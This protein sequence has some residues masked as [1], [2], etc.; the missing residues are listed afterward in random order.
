MLCDSLATV[1]PKLD[2]VAAV[3]LTQTGSE[4][5]TLPG[6]AAYSAA[7]GNSTAKH[8]HSFRARQTEAGY[9]RLDAF[10]SDAAA[11]ALHRLAL[12][13]GCTK[14]EVIEKLVT[15]AEATYFTGGDTQ[16]QG[17]GK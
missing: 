3:P 2:E 16:Q 9:R 14:R 12:V 8:Q 13:L 6:E 5:N 15:V 10:I 1:R 7:M 11:C 17:D 4:S